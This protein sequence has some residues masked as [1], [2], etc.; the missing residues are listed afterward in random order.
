[1][2]TTDIVLLIP[3]LFG[4]IRGLWSGLIQEV[5][6]IIGI[7]VGLILGYMFNEDVVIM[8]QEEFDMSNESANITAFALLFIGGFLI[9]LVIAKILTKGTSAAGLGMLNRILGGLFAALKY[10]VFTSVLLT[11]FDRINDSVL[12]IEK[13]KLA[14]SIVYKAYGEF[15]DLLWDYVPEEKGGFDLDSSIESIQDRLDSR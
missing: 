10:A 13:E 5:A 3:V 11:F 15:S 6:G 2:N 7:V 4:F 12:I 9:V 14:E 8:L 1:M